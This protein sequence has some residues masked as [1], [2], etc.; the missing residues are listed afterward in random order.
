VSILDEASSRAVDVTDVPA[1]ADGVELLGRMRGSGYRRPP[2][3]VRRGDGQTLQL[4]PL[5]YLVLDN[6]DGRRDYGELAAAVSE[7]YGRTVPAEAVRELV[8]DKLMPLGVLRLADGSQPDVRKASPLLRLRFRFVVTDPVVTR[9]ITAPFAWLFNPFVVLAVVAAFVVTT[10][11]VLFVHGLAFAAHE[12][13]TRPGLLLAVFLITL[14]SAGL[15]E[16]GHAAAARY[17]GATPG[18]MGAGIYLAWP[19]FYTDVTDSYRLGRAGRIRTDLGGLY[20]NAVLSVAV[21]GVW[22]LTRW[23]ALLLVIATQLIQM[24]RQLPPMVRFDGYHL[25]ADITGVPDLFHRIGPT[26]RSLVPFRRR[27]EQATALKP[28]ARVV[29]SL[30]VI[31]IVPLML[32]ML[33]VTVLALPRILASAAAGA[34]RQWSQMMSAFSDGAVLTGLAKLLGVIAIVIPVLGIAVMLTT[35]V[36]RT[37]QRTIQR[38]QGQPVRRGFAGIV[39]AAVLIALAFAWWPHGNYRKIEPY[40]RGTLQQAFASVQH[41]TD[42]FAAGRQLSAQ[43]VWPAGVTQLPTRDHPALSVVMVPRTDKSAPTW[44]FPFDRPLPPGAGDNQTLAVNT[45][46]GTTV[47]DVAFALV[48]ADGDTV[49]NKNEAYA[50][51]SCTQCTAVA[52]SFQIILVV[53]QANVVV[54]QNISEAVSYN[55]IQCVTQALALQLVVSLPDNPSAAEAAE[56]AVLWQ[57]IQAFG[58]Q[59][60]GLSFDEI[61]SRLTAYEDQILAIVK[62]YAPPGT[63]TSATSTTGASVSGSAGDTATAGAAVSS[64]SVPTGDGGAATSGAVDSA[65]A[66]SGSAP[67]DSTAPDASS[68]PTDSVVPTTPVTSP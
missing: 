9:R 3:L 66:T 23:D 58:R 24:I 31:A 15:H 57:Q 16:F 5:L 7:E 60:Q 1:R 25:L 26:L 32:L 59:V 68:N 43:T 61:Q 11:W 67:A 64:G 55:C 52:V 47:Y 65:A 44:V 37:A 20:F 40:E 4:T 41:G 12:A 6:I 36:R 51:A 17:G 33:L 38:T 49:L 2:A 30:W 35:T 27:E 22:A 21:F 53:G 10:G 50:F 28:W 63:T 18:A 54:P 46:N 62:K 56:L 34:S 14:F 13:F 19:A 8:Q 39:A 42:G 29:V 45:K 48:W